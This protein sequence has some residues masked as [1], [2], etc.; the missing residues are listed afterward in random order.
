[1]ATPYAAEHRDLES[2]FRRL[3]SKIAELQAAGARRPAYVYESGELT[4]SPGVTFT[5]ATTT[6]GLF[7]Y[8]FSGTS[9]PDGWTFE[10]YA[11]G[12]PAVPGIS[13]VD[14]GMPAG[15]AGSSLL[16]D[17]GPSGGDTTL[18]QSAQVVRTELSGSIDYEVTGRVAS[19][20]A[21]PGS[22]GE[23][24]SVF[25][26]EGDPIGDTSADAVLLNFTPAGAPR[27][28]AVV[29]GSSSTLFSLPAGLTANTWHRFRFR[30][31][32]GRVEAA[33][34]VDGT[35][36]PA[37]VSADLTSN[38]IQGLCGVEYFM[39]PLLTPA[40]GTR[41]WFDSITVEQLGGGFTVNPD[42]TGDWPAVLDPIRARIEALEAFH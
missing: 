39:Q 25:V 37:P 6:T 26:R 22:P 28:Q 3:E 32:S 34:W 31:A 29:N 17:L 30:V 8:P 5:V 42:G 38:L 21:D 36:E 13:V 11:N 12:L 41:V 40:T 20:I 2:R 18:S 14:T 35:T 7:E 1:M 33:V 15:G 24:V 9:L 10:Q 4:I 16:V 19:N 23:R 27:V